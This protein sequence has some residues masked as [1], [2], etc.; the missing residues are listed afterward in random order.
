LHDIDLQCTYYLVTLSS[1]SIIGSASM[2]HLNI[3]YIRKKYC[4]Q[5]PGNFLYKSAARIQ[6]VDYTICRA[7][8]LNR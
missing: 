5:M 8:Y 1:R 4:E 7:V 3:K 2:I 6:K